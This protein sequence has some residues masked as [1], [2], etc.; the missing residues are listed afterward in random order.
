ML[1]ILPKISPLSRENLD[2]LVEFTIEIG[3]A[4]MRELILASPAAGFLLPL[5]TALEWEPGL[6]PRVAR[7]VEEV[8]GD[9]RRRLEERREARANGV[10]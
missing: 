5:T 8:A 6:K 4:R 9:I 7:E 3:A 1:A 10:G 2:A